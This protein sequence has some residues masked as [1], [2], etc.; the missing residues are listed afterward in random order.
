MFKSLINLAQ[1]AAAYSEEHDLFCEMTTMGLLRWGYLE[2]GKWLAD[3]G[4][5]DRPD[6]VFMMNTNEI[7]SSVMVPGKADM[8]WLTRR[9]RKNGRH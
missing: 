6:D 4:C 9:R 7:E 1:Q 5:I 2:I 8:R 3:Q